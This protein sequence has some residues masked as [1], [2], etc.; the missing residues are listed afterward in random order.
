VHRNNCPFGIEFCLSIRVNYHYSSRCASAIDR[1]KAQRR[2]REHMVSGR[3]RDTWKAGNN[4][5]RPI[6]QSKVKRWKIRVVDYVGRKTIVYLLLT[7]YIDAHTSVSYGEYT[8]IVFIYL[9][10]YCFYRFTICPL[11]S[12]INRARIYIIRIY[13]CINDQNKYLYKPKYLRKHMF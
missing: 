2:R 5:R 11:I 3:T 8:F 7:R 6:K 10:S 4:R 9:I 12:V 1:E 13:M